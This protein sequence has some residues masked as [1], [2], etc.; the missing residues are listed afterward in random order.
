MKAAAVL[1]APSGKRNELVDLI[2][3]EFE[4]SRSFGPDKGKLNP[5]SRLA[6]DVFQ[7]QFDPAKDQFSDRAAFTGS[8]GFQAS[9]ERIGNVDGRTHGSIVRHL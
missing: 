3:V 8:A 9:I 5:S 2:I 7:G 6:G 4:R 1:V